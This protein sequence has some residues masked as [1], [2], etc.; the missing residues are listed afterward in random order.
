MIGYVVHYVGER[1]AGAYVNEHAWTTLV[2]T[3]TAMLRERPDTT[4]CIEPVD[5]VP[6][7]VVFQ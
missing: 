3:A 5:E 2:T 7:W 4:V 6:S 1:D